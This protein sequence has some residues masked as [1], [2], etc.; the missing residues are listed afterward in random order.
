MF[1]LFKKKEKV[2]EPLKCNCGDWPNPAWTQEDFLKKHEMVKLCPIHKGMQMMMV[3]SKVQQQIPVPEAP[4]MTP[5]DNLGME[6]R[7]ARIHML[8]CI[9]IL[10]S[11]NPLWV[12]LNEMIEELERI[13][14][15]QNK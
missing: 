4:D 9:E 13:I 5:F 6:L 8:N 7:S 11:T 10:A 15:E 2:P 12:E 14:Q 3:V 1:N